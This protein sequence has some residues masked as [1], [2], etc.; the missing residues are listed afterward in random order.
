V[1]TRRFEGRTAVITGAASGI[2][3]AVALRLAAQGKAT[4]DPELARD[5]AQLMEP[6]S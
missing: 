4:T 5:R 6:T 1:S 2:G 3:L